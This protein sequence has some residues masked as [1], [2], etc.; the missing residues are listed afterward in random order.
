VAAGQDQGAT[1]RISGRP[2]FGQ[3]P[4]G[5]PGLGPPWPGPGRPGARPGR[6]KGP[7]GRRKFPGK[8]GVDGQGHPGRQFRGQT[9]PFH[10]H[11]AGGNN[12]QDQVVQAGFQEVDFINIQKPPTG[13]A[14][15]ARLENRAAGL[16]SRRGARS[17][18]GLVGS[19]RPE[20]GVRPGPG[21]RWI[22]PCLFLPSGE[23]RPERGPRPRSSR[24]ETISY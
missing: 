7:P 22:W 24:A 16:R 6:T 19:D 3:T 12:V 2:G 23:P 14:H 11:P 4:G 8:V 9:L 21:P 13:L 18:R 1:A 15:Q 17:G 10:P 20:A 5:R